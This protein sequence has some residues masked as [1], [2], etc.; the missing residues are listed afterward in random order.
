MKK[1]SVPIPRALFH[2]QATGTCDFYIFVSKVTI[3]FNQDYSNVR[4]HIEINQEVTP[5]SKVVGRG[6]DRSV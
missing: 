1:Q 5:V 4:E 2:R 6:T 3:S